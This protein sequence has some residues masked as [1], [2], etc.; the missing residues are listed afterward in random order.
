MA[1]QAQEEIKQPEAK[2]SIELGLWRHGPEIPRGCGLQIRFA[3]NA[4]R[5]SLSASSTWRAT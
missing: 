2:V 1:A 3:A 5:D 4:V